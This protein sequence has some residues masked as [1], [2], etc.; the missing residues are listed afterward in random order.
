MKI[1]FE[2]GQTAHIELL[3]N[4]WVDYWRS[5]V[6]PLEERGKRIHTWNEQLWPREG[7]LTEKE[8]AIQHEQTELFNANVDRLAADYGIQFPGKMWV[9]QD[10]LWLNKIHRWVTHGAHTKAVWNLPNASH[11]SII[12]SKRGHWRDYQWQQDHQYREFEIAEE[13]VAAVTKI[14]FDMNCEIHEYE[15]TIRSPRVNQLRDMGFEPTDGYHLIQRY[16]DDSRPGYADC[17]DM[18]P[19]WRRFCSHDDYDLWMPFAVLGKEYYT[20]WINIDSPAHFDVTNIDKTWFAGFE[21]QPNNFMNR[22]LTSNQFQS[23]LTVHGIPRDPQLIA[24][25]P[26][27]TCTNK[28]DLNLVECVRSQVTQ[29][30]FE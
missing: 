4:A 1:H 22:V 7:A 21:F 3:K 8:E 11:E 5:V 16:F 14:L 26:L 20:T 28:A 30:E 9:G 6:Q 10:Q 25:L 2:N 27:G 17:Y 15:E 18:N 19:D 29:V 23:W 12:A 13:N 24:K